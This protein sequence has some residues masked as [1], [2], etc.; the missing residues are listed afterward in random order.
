M[1]KVIFTAE[2]F[3]L[4]SSIDALTQ[5]FR[6]K[7]ATLLRNCRILLRRNMI[8]LLKPYKNP[9]VR[10]LSLIKNIKEVTDSLEQKHVELVGTTTSKQEDTLYRIECSLDETQQYL[11]RDC[12]EITG[13]TISLMIIPNTLLKKLARLYRSRDR[14]Q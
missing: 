13:V 1:E 8:V 11:R 3:E 7:D 6:L 4:K 12:L 9:T 10:Q 2:I 14:G 5:R